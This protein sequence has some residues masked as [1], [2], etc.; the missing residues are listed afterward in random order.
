MKF[1][2][3][4]PH[5]LWGKAGKSLDIKDLKASKRWW[6]SFLS[7]LFVQ[8]YRLN[9]IS[10]L[11]EGKKVQLSNFCTK[12]KRLCSAFSSTFSFQLMHKPDPHSWTRPWWDFWPDPL[13]FENFRVFNLVNWVSGLL[14]DLRL[15]LSVSSRALSHRSCGRFQMNMRCLKRRMPHQRGNAAFLRESADA[16]GLWLINYSGITRRPWPDVK[17][18]LFCFYYMFSSSR[19][20]V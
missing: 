20:S 13:H 17:E 2:S 1:Q 9:Y 12:M 15:A 7:E 10:S 14:K 18:D 4:S 3:F 5:V 16:C 8:Y 19:F 6:F 11:R